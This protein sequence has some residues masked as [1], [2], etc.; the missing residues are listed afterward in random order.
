M[1]SV[2]SGK[3]GTGKT[4]L[5]TALAWVA[6]SGLSWGRGAGSAD[7]GSRLGTLLWS[8]DRTSHF[9]SSSARKA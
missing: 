7:R 2:A 1:I 9:A 5:A 8:I 4:M 6:G 3:G